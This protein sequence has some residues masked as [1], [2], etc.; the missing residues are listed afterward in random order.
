MRNDARFHCAKPQF[1]GAAIFHYMNA[2]KKWNGM[3]YICARKGVQFPRSFSTYDVPLLRGTMQAR[4]T[5]KFRL[6]G[7]L[8]K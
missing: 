7:G 2:E 4:Q 8:S 3:L 6:D 1:P 5:K